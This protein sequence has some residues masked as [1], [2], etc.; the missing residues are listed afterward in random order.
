MGHLRE[1]Y[2]DPA[3]QEQIAAPAVPAHTLDMALI[4]ATVARVIG[5]DLAQVE[6]ITSA[7]M[8]DPLV[9]QLGL[10]LVAEL[11]SSEPR[12]QTYVDSLVQALIVHVAH[13]HPGSGK[14]PVEQAGGLAGPTLQRVLEYIGENLAHDLA[15]D[16][17]ADVAGMSPY[18]FTRLFK[19]AVGLPV[20]RY[21]TQR[22]LIAA[23]QLLLVG[24]H[25]I[26]QVAA[27]TGFADQSHLHRNF[28]ATYGITPGAIL[29]QSKNV[30]RARKNIQDQNEQTE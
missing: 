5:H 7:S 17:I 2:T 30:Q 23:R 25:S 20:H 6:L 22:R 8:D 10:A 3:E 16:A 24:A 29:E 14:A 15:L 18:H 21:V 1:A 28:K 13:K 12:N 11:Q 4:A 26:A 19:Q 27:L 9:Y